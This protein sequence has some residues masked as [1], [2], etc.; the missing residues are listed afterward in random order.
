MPSIAIL[1]LVATQARRAMLG[2]GQD[3]HFG[4][5]FAHVPV[6]GSAGLSLQIAIMVKLGLADMLRLALKSPRKILV[7]QLLS[8]GRYLLLLSRAFVT[9]H[10]PL[11]PNG[12]D[13]SPYSIHL[14]QPYKAHFGAER[15]FCTWT[16]FDRRSFYV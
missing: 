14:K 8:K 9:G 3:C 11:V 2:A 13:I 1:A 4:I 15:V 6:L 12:F 7:F 16:T 10:G 5:V